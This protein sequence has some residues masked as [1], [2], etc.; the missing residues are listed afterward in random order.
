LD[1]LTVEQYALQMFNQWGVGKKGVD[2]GVLVLVAPSDRKIR[3]EVGYGLEPILPDGLAGAII[4]TQFLPRFRQNNYT[5]GI[6]DGVARLVTIVRARHI[7]TPEERKRLAAAAHE[8]EW[9]MVPFF[10]MFVGVGAVAIGLGVRAKAVA[11]I[12]FGLVFA[13][14]ILL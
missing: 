10:A 7:V 1:G 2:N 6:R 8:N 4:R 3:I 12:F 11:A 5:A 13:I 9:M 14:P